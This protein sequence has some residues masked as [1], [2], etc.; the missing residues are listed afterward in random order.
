LLASGDVARLRLE[1]GAS[2]YREASDNG[3]N[4]AP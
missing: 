2:R 4:N 3:A 1:E